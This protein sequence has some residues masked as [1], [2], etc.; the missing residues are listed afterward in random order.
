MLLT[1]TYSP[2]SIPIILRF[3]L[4]MVSHISWI[5]CIFWVKLLLNLMLS[6]TDQS[7]SSISLFYL[8]YSAVHACNCGSW[9]FS[10]DFC[11]YNSLGLCLIY[12]LNFSFQ[13]LNNFFHMFYF[14]FLIFFKGFAY[15]FHF[16]FVFSSIS[17]RE[18]LISS[19]RISNILLKFYLGQFL[20]LHLY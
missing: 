18:F 3:D 1:W 9:L 4:F 15:V 10:H 8:L 11:F 2:S 13:V 20:L 12:C 7:I 16:L 19:L 5:F 6:L 14:F 17:L